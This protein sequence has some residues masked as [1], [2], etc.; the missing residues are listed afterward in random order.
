[1]I[2][3]FTTFG[4]LALICG[5]VG[6]HDVLHEG[7]PIVYALFSLFLLGWIGAGLAIV[8]L[9]VLRRRRGRLTSSG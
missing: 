4:C 1:M 8:G 6:F 2:Y 7:L 9:P 3:A 5:L